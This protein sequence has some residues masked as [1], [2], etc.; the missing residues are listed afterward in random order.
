V[1][2]PN[3]FIIAIKAIRELGSPQLANYALYQLGLKTGYLHWRTPVKSPGIGSRQRPW[4]PP[5]LQFKPFLELPDPKRLITLLGDNL[6]SCLKEADEIVKGNVHLFGGPSVALELSLPGPLEHWTA[7]E[8]GE[9]VP[10][11]QDIK[12]VWEPGRF[13]WAIKLGR[14]FYISGDEKYS[15]AFWHFT[16]QFL[17][18]NPSNLGPHWASAQ[19]VAFRL[20]ALSFA[21]HVFINS[22]HSSPERVGQLLGAISDHANRIPLTLRYAQA[23]NNNHLLAE[24]AGLYTAGYILP[25]YP[26]AG[27]WRSLGKFWLD[28]GFMS[29]IAED[30][31]YIQHSTNYH[32]LMLQIALWVNWVGSSIHSF[33]KSVDKPENPTLFSSLTRA[34]LKA[35]TR[36]LLALLDEQSGRLP[37][38]GPNDGADILPLTSCSYYDYRPV[39]KAAALAFLEEQPFPEGLWDEMSIWC[40]LMN[41]NQV[42]DDQKNQPKIRLAR[43]LQPLTKDS[44]PVLHGTHSW[45]YLRVAKFNHRP[46]HADQLNLDLWW[47]GLNITQDAGTYL[48]NANKPWDNS[49]SGTAVHNT[50]SV[51]GKDQMTRAGRFLWLDWAQGQIIDYERATNGRLIRIMAQHNGYEALGVIHRREV[52][53]SKRD[54]WN[55]NDQL[56]PSSKIYARKIPDHQRNSFDIRIHWLLPDWRWELDKSGDTS[57]CQMRIKSPHGWITLQTTTQAEFSSTENQEPPIIRIIRGGELLQ[58]PGPAGS[59]YGWFS[60]TYGVKVPS[61]SFSLDIRTTLPLR[62]TTKWA[63]P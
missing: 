40:G 20:I 35:A 58:G 42:S 9:K 34:R 28:Q 32:R 14:A 8:K 52:L 57:E 7:Y 41:S 38:L 12:W 47:R 13:G 33:E 55:I 23:Q 43:D 3:K 30:G 62:I 50:I 16:Q 4:L 15:Q 1:R 49:L 60:P 51:Q 54:H 18:S 61:I 6:P 36:W 44:F 10:G 53:V 21:L 39:S 17:N 19:E 63:F 59:I 29:Q 27:Y 24:A 22:S 26:K 25:G 31:T 56:I 48:Y 46:G 37:N 5:N 45:A 2:S 11:H